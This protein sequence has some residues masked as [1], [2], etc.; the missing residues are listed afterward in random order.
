MSSEVAQELKMNPAEI[1]IQPIVLTSP[2]KP[3]E[4][5]NK[6]GSSKGFLATFAVLLAG[7]LLGNLILLSILGVGAVTLASSTGLIKV[8]FLTNYFFGEA[9]PIAREIDNYS[10]HNG[11]EKIQKIQNLSEGET[12]SSLVFYEDE[13]NALLANK[14]QTDPNF[15]VVWQNLSLLNGAFVFTGNMSATNAPVVIKGKVR[16]EGLTGEIE[17]TEAKYGKLEIPNFLATNIV[18]SQLSSIGL[19]LTGNRVPAKALELSAGM[20]KLTNVTQP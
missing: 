10:L 4:S 12:I 15:P 19:S 16:T 14:A 7:W 17:I 9:S 18:E 2:E 11:E 6:Q 20:L 8:P 13:I 3:A 1:P 5:I